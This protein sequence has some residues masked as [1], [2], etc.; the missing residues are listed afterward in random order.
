MIQ[1]GGQGFTVLD[2]VLRCKAFPGTPPVTCYL[3]SWRMLQY[4]EQALLS[5]IYALAVRLRK[6]AWR[7]RQPTLVGV[8]LLIVRGGPPAQAGSVLLVRHRA[9]RK[10]W[11][12][13]GGG[14][15]RFERLAEAAR[16]EA[17]EETGV[18]VR[19]EYLLGAY[20]AFRIGV[21]NYIAVFVCAA[22]G[23]PRPPR[24]LEIA[25]ARF[26]PFGQLPDGL[27]RGSRRRIA[28]YLA[29]ERGISRL[30]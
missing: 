8:R 18:V 29:G 16:R 6:L 7:V 17:L 20:D 25:E 9:G 15:E 12:L 30:W 11:S 19:V 10:P 3:S 24:S 2:N 5:P 23:E 28:E 27:D 21:S 26:V 14:V 4:L 22:L 13:P 1:S